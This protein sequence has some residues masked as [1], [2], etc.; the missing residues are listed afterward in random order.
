V[1]LQAISYPR[2]G[3]WGLNTQLDV[4][5]DDEQR[6]A[7]TAL[8]GVIGPD[9]KLASRKDFSRLT[10]GFSGTVESITVHKHNDGTESVL[11]AAAGHLYSGTTTLTDRWDYSGTSTT[12]NSWMYA[13]LSSRVFL[14]QGGMSPKCLNEST[15]ANVA[16]T[17]PTVA[18]T[19]PDVVRA[20]SGRLWAANDA[21]GGNQYTLWWSNLQDGTVWNAGDAGLL[22]VRKVW[23]GGY[24]IITNVVIYQDR[25]LIFGKQNI[26][27][28]TLPADRNPA[29]MSLTDSIAGLGCIARDSVIVAGGDLYFL[30]HDGY[31]RLSRLAQVTS[32]LSA[33]KITANVADDFVDSLS[34]ETLSKVR[35][36]YDPTNKL[37][38]LTLPTGN[39][40]WCFHPDRNVVTGVE[41]INVPAVTRWTN[42]SNPFRGFAFNNAGD[43]Y[44]AMTDGVGQYNTFTPPAASSAYTFQWYQLWNPIQNQTRI[45]SLKSVG[46]T[47]EAASGQTGTLNWQID[48]VAGTTRTSS[49]TCDATD[50][51]ENPGIGVVRLPIGGHCNVARIGTSHTINGSKVTVHGLRIYATPGASRIR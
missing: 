14:F 11:S 25:V 44:C 45:K 24:D 12:L 37:V 2:P 13:S 18:W 16:I 47:L 15:W 26:L 4:L 27:M 34:G 51:A 5:E 31:Y 48:Y 28:Y 49:F 46:L 22:D 38:L 17:A 41:G 29:S 35:A 30:A 32:L 50:F 7:A 40:V 1:A 21:A 6:F 23:P 8:N 20:G 36:G 33:V 3:S 39:V 10:S 19:S 43:F 42:T 9:G